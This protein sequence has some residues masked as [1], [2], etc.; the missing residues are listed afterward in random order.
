MSRSSTSNAT[1]AR[2]TYGSAMLARAAA[3]PALT[4]LPADPASTAASQSRASSRTWFGPT[5]AATCARTV[6][7]LNRVRVSRN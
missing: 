1:T 6:Y 3:C 4:P 7:I 2:R 5:S